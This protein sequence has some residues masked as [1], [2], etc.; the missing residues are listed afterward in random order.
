MNFC[1]FRHETY[2]FMQTGLR[3]QK[4]IGH[5]MK[6]QKELQNFGVYMFHYLLLLKFNFIHTWLKMVSD[7]DCLL[8]QILVRCLYVL[9]D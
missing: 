5:T 7:R 4:M 8:D 9:F 2:G 6:W 3:K 1:R